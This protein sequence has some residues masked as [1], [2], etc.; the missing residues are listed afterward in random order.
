MCKRETWRGGESRSC[1]KN[2]A[3]EHALSNLVWCIFRWPGPHAASIIQRL[4]ELTFRPALS[5]PGLP[6]LCQPL[7]IPLVSH[8]QGRSENRPGESTQAEAGT[9]G[10]CWG[11]AGGAGVEGLQGGSWG[12]P[13]QFHPVF[14]NE[15]KGREWCPLSPCHTG[16]FKKQP[17]WF[18][19]WGV[20]S[21]DKKRGEEWVGE[22]FN[23][24]SVWRTSS[25]RMA[26]L[27]FVKDWASSLVLP[28][29][30]SL[31]PWN[32]R[33][34]QAQNLYHWSFSG[35]WLT[36]KGKV[37]KSFLKDPSY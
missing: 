16:T 2:R 24:G 34:A 37:R 19:K 30:S 28:L 27:A 15:R 11:G 36:V 32:L 35:N 13:F 3:G 22:E 5:T 10:C 12:P 9:V 8:R 23:C 21:R 4:I 29:C 31:A 25:G 18:L 17:Q 6:V 7:T 33:W 26:T 1:K 20:F 14:P